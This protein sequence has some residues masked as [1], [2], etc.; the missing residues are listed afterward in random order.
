MIRAVVAVFIALFVASPVAQAGY[1]ARVAELRR[2]LQTKQLADAKERDVLTK[3]LDEYLKDRQD[4]FDALVRLVE[5]A[6]ADAKQE[7]AWTSRL[8]G[9]KEDAVQLGNAIKSVSGTPSIDA[10]HF[11]ATTQVEEVSFF[12]NSRRAR[13]QSAATRSP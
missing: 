5:E 8:D 13:S 4:C 3:A 1:D 7:Q 2:L 12:T 11:L 9:C 10:Y 6:S